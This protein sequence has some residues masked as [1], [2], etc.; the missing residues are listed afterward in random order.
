MISE[1]LPDIVQKFSPCGL[2]FQVFAVLRYL[3]L[4]FHGSAR[5]VP[6]VCVTRWWA[7]RDKAIFSESTSSHVNCLKT[8]R[9]PPVGCTPCWAAAWEVCATYIGLFVRHYPNP[10]EVLTYRLSDGMSL[11]RNS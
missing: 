3:E 10:I 11:G 2:S 5:S 7:G 8:R 6:T 1:I 9:L 4:H